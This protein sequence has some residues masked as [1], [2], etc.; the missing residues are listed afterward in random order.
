[1]IR[2]NA[3]SEAKT[4]WEL[5]NIAADPSEIHNVIADYP[6]KTEELKKLLREAHMYDPNWP[7]LEGEKRNNRV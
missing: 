4:T 5:Y 1:M 2:L 7:L 6:R 3:S